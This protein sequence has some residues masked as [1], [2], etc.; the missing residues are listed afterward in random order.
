ML[1]RYEEAET[2][3]GRSLAIA[4]AW[5]RQTVPYVAVAT[6]N[7]GD[8]LLGLGRHDEARKHYERAIELIGDMMGEGSRVMAEARKGLGLVA[9]AE[10]DRGQALRQLRRA[11]DI[12]NAFAHDPL[13]SADVH[14]ALAQ[15]RWPTDQAHSRELA[16]RALAGYANSGL[17]RQRQRIVD[18]L[19]E[20]RP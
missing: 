9:L 1:G 20:R 6:S 16:E 13:L 10:G 19:A 11:M 15:A 12:L 14:F 8:A 5:S 18:W 17:H 2:E 7:L 4:E 3:L